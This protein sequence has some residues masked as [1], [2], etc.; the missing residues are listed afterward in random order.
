MLKIQPNSCIHQ[1]AHHWQHNPVFNTHG[2]RPSFPGQKNS[3]L[4]VYNDPVLRHLM[5]SIFLSLFIFH[6][7]TSLFL[8]WYCAS[9]HSGHFHFVHPSSARRILNPSFTY[10]SPQHASSSVHSIMFTPIYMCCQSQKQGLMT[11]KGR[12]YYPRFNSKK[13]RETTNIGQAL[14]P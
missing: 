12:L 9:F 13:L 5:I 6:H 8:L 1:F 2:T 14:R 3:S 11:S 4:H 10:I 7:Q